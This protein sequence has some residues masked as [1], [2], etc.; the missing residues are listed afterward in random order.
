MRN[1]R[2]N[3]EEYFDTEYDFLTW[4]FEYRTHSELYM[5]FLKDKIGIVFHCY[6]FRNIYRGFICFIDDVNKSSEV[7]KIIEQHDL[8]KNPELWTED[9]KMIFRLSLS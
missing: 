7:D 1:R 8:P 2:L 9:Q 6:Y 5:G 3:G 4:L